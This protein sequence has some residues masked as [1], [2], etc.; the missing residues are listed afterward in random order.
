VHELYEA[1]EIEVVSTRRNI[2]SNA[3]T[4]TGE[5]VIVTALPYPRFAIR[6]VPAS[7]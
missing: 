6:E 4:R 5:D 7:G 3:K 1:F 2:S